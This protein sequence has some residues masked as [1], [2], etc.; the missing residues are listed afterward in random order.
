MNKLIQCFALWILSYPLFSQNWVQVGNL[1]NTPSALL[2]D[3]VSGLLYL[4]GNFRFNG[5]DTVDGFCAYDGNSFTSFGRRYDCITFGCDPAFMIARYGEQLYLSGPGLTI[6][7]GVDV[8]GIGQWDGTTWS[9]GMPGLYQHENDHNPF[10]DGYCINDGF[11]YG[12]GSFRTAE[13]DTCNSVA[14]WDGQK[15]TGLDFPPY[16]DNS[17]PRTTSVIFYQNQLYVSGNFSWAQS[18]G[19]DIARLDSTGWHMVGGGLKGGL[20]FVSDMEIYKGELYICGY[21]RK[22]DGNV[23]NKIMRWDG[24]QWKEVGAGF[25]AP[26]VTAKAMMVHDGK[27]YVV[28]I[29]DCVEN[30]LY[31]SNIATWDGERWCSLGDS[32]FNNTIL[33]I[34]TYKGEIYIGGGFTLVDGQPCR[35]FA[36]YVGDHSTDTCSAPISAAPEPTSEGF[37]L[38]PNP[39]TDIL[40]VQA[41]AP[42]ESVWVYDAMGR[43]VLR[44]K[45]SG[46]R[47]SVSLGHLPAGLYFVSLR[48]D[49][50]VWGGRFWKG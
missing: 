18:G 23:G 9:A 10:L 25:C 21:F 28:G 14:Y 29:F 12:V 16:S 39:V 27:L 41:P 47:V 20:S 7:D 31:A 46:E 44:P 6:L 50:V 26:N 19:A 40:Q 8:K 11:F 43:E 22:L 36:K 32:Y 49:G 45:V 42:I 34:T 48:A 1:N 37:G 17:L 24:Q 13:G 4:A 5:V 33:N 15:W 2:N 30:G 3:S 38:W 35:Y